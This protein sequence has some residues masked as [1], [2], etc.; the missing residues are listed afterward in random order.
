MT[1]AGTGSSPAHDRTAGQAGFVFIP[2]GGTGEIGMNFNIYG[3][4][5]DFLAV[6]CGMGFSGPENPETE[7]L[8]PDHQQE[9]R[10]RPQDR[11]EEAL[12]EVAHVAL[13]FP[14]P[15]R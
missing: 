4:D 5:G 12:L 10:R 7:I 11:L 1:K 6:D 13:I 14:H 2:L 15:P 3:C 9:H 8:L